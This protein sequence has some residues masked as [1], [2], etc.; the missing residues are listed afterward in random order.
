MGVLTNA[1]TW[2]PVLK[3]ARFGYFRLTSRV[4]GYRGS[5]DAFRPACSRWHGQLRRCERNRRLG[6]RSSS[7]VRRRSRVVSRRWAIGTSGIGREPMTTTDPRLSDCVLGGY[8]VV[9]TKPRPAWAR[10]V[11]PDRIVSRS[12]CLVGELADVWLDAY[13]ER[14]GD[15]ETV[16]G[17]AQERFGLE[18][19]A[20]D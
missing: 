17:Q 15:L 13:R 18:R 5:T 8:S 3:R 19:A 10:V 16:Y 9:L 2:R 14:E 6:R 12:R 20:V 1:P 4:P 11:L 7:S